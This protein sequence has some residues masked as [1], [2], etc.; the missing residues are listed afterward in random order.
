MKYCYTGFQSGGDILDFL[1]AM[2]ESSNFSTSL[3]LVIAILVGMKKHLIVLLTYSFHMTDVLS[4]F[5][6]AYG[7]FLSH[8]WKIF[9]CFFPFHITLRGTSKTVLVL[10]QF[11]SMIYFELNLV[12]GWYPALTSFI[13]TWTTLKTITIPPTEF[14]KHL[15]INSIEYMLLLEN[16]QLYSTNVCVYPL[17]S[18]TLFWL[19]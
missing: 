5:S 2:F 10:T 6:C 15:W 11:I 8:H 17:V 9:K 12:C 13:W 19:L 4:I 14:Y 1:P 16:L 7:S 3:P 18:T